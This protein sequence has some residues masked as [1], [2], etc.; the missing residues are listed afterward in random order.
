MLSSLLP[1]RMV[2]L[3]LQTLVSSI[4]FPKLLFLDLM[5]NNTKIKSF[6]I[7]ITIFHL[8]TT[9]VEGTL[10]Y[11]TTSKGENCE[12][13]EMVST[14]EEC[15]LASERLGRK[16]VGRTRSRGRPAG[17]YWA[18]KSLTNREHAYSYVNT[19][20][21]ASSTEPTNGRKHG[22]ICKKSKN[23]QYTGLL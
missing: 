10:T 5:W 21:D 7:H 4:C 14:E 9:S 16:Y 17:C 12:N 13:D 8:T 15:K 23:K 19:I 6:C 11:Y 3:M 1:L 2:I 18:F 22:G 20:V